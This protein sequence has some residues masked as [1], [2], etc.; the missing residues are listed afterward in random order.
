[1][2]WLAA[3]AVQ[4]AAVEWL[5]FPADVTSAGVQLR[6]WWSPAAPAF[7]GDR[8]AGVMLH[9]CGGML[10]K[11]GEP[12]ARMREYAQM[13][14]A[15]GWHTLAVDSLTP[16]GETE[17]CTQRAAGRRVK[18]SDRALDALSAL[19]WLARQPGVDASRLA[20][21]GWSNGGSTLLAAT[22]ARHAPV[23]HRFRQ[24]TGQ[25]KLAVAFYPGCLQ[26]ARSGYQP[27]TQTWLLLGEADDWTPA[28]DCL[29]LASKQVHIRS[30]P[31]AGHGF[32]STAPVRYRADVP[33][34]ANPGQGVHVGG[35]PEARLA[36]QQLLL[37]LLTQAFASP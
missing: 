14:N 15:K 9:G 34:G 37:Q 19:D 7:S 17:L 2:L 3:Y 8:P 35:H 33:N 20:M 12:S 10:N 6:A 1:M 32:D 4:G 16:R 24:A 23:A 36:S 13:L 27:V 28:V 11:Q 18:V 29:P 30:W 25:L 22:N 5:S 21:L 31:G 26:A